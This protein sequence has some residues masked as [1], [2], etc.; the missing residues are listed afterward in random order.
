MTNKEKLVESTVKLLAEQYDREEYGFKEEF[1]ELY[2]YLIDSL[3][4]VLPD[5]QL[6]DEPE[7]KGQHRTTIISKSIEIKPGIYRYIYIRV[8]C[9]LPNHRSNNEYYWELFQLNA[10]SEVKETSSESVNIYGLTGEGYTI[11]NK[12]PDANFS[13]QT[14][15]TSNKDVYEKR[16]QKLQ[17]KKQKIDEFVQIIAKSYKNIDKL[18]IASINDIFE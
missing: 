7:I 6:K 11:T 9:A 8:E 17:D 12:I 5:M 1:Y 16:V 3:K 10:Y 2:D 4:K 15:T 13:I 14:H 18:K